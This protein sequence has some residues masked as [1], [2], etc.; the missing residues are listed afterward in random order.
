M[1]T[2]TF[3]ADQDAIYHLQHLLVDYTAALDYELANLVEPNSI[4]VRKTVNRLDDL[5]AV[6]DVIKAR[7][8][9]L[10]A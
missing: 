2:Q 10:Q 4:L 8:K 6:I 3:E 9:S 1:Q 7:I 5:T